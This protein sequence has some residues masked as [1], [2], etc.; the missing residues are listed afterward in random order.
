MTRT[1]LY[2]LAVL[3]LG[4][5]VWFFLFRDQKVFSGREANFTVHDTAAVGRIFLA[6]NAGEQVSLERS[7]DGWTVNGE[8]P[9]LQAHVNNLLRTLHEQQVQNKVTKNAY[10]NVIKSMAGNA[11]KCELYNRNGKLMRRFFVGLETHN[12]GGTYMLMDGAEEPFVVQIPGFAGFLTPRYQPK[13]A[14]WRD[15]HIFSYP[16]QEIQSI[17]VRYPL[18]NLNDFTV[19]WDGKDTNS[20][21]VKLAPEMHFE[22][23]KPVMGKTRAYLNF[24]ADIYGEAYLN[25]EAQLDS[26]LAS[27]PMK[28]EIT[29]QP[30]NG[31]A[32]KIQLFYY[33]LNRRSKNLDNESTDF[34]NDWDGDRYYA[35]VHGGK[36]TM[37]VQRR[38][39]DKMLRR[40]YEF[41]Q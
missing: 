13:A 37:L 10:N 35:V 29:I 8:Y 41:F 4:A 32:E 3:I 22:G 7:G 2:V 24:Y 39:F 28:S 33:P 18:N 27:V 12:Y 15:R 34:E 23:K 26:M 20:V 16:A 30:K 36:D 14:F 5:G 17:S 9:A 25:G 21:A 19:S 11:I 1:L 31:P 40:G 6:N 38:I